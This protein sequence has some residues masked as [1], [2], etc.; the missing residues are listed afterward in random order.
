MPKIWQSMFLEAIIQS[1]ALEDVRL[2]RW[3]LGIDETSTNPDHACERLG[4]KSIATSP[5]I[6]GTPEKELV[7]ISASWQ[8]AK[9]GGVA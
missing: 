6:Y 7:H 5:E 3:R 2:P 4:R 9:I 8:D 1:K